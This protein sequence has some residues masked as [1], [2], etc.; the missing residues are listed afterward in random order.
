MTLVLLT[1]CILTP[2]NIAFNLE[3][4]N[5]KLKVVD[6]MID[7]LFFVD[8]IVIFNSAYYTDDYECVDDRPTIAKSYISGWLLVD[9][10]SIVPF[11]WIL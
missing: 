9:T 1:T 11:D 10:L 4:S 6:Y 8:I 7:F 3:E 2:L 5:R